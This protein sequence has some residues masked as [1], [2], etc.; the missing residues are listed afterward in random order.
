MFTVSWPIDNVVVGWSALGRRM[1]GKMLRMTS[2]EE[3]GAEISANG[4]T[5]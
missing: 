2:E 3:K 4:K 1:M 5:M